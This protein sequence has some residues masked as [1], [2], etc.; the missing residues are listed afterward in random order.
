MPQ[1][2]QQVEH[3][4][5]AV[6]ARLQQGQ[7]GQGAHLQV[8]LREVTGVQGVVAA[9]VR[10]RR[11]F[12]DDER[13]VLQHKKLHAQHAHVMQAVRDG[14]GGGNGL[15]GQFGRQVAVKHFGHRQNTVAVQVE[16]HRQVDASA[17]PATRHDH[18]AFGTQRQHFFQHAGH[19]LE[20]RPGGGQFGAGGDAGLALAVV[21]Q[22]RGFENARQQVVRHASELLGGLDH[23]VGRAGHAAAHKM[24]L[25]LGPVLGNAHRFGVGRHGPVRA[26][27]DE[28]GRRHVFK[29]GGD[30]GT[31][32]H[33]LRQ[34]LFVEVIGL[35]VV[36]AHQ[37]GGADHVG[38]EHHGEIT[39]GLRCL[40]KHAAQLA[41]PHHAQ[42]GGLTLR[43]AARQNSLGTHSAGGSVMARAAWVCAAR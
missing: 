13:A 1:V 27:G 6:L 2:T 11:H 21:A 4:G 43:A 5:R 32:L 15:L 37:T 39:H 28:G 30:G 8:K 40:H 3:D 33:Q 23:G 26:Q 38:V 22:P 9:V 35:D 14:A 12:V 16:L 36:V 20:R 17:V 10:T 41:T 42:C 25:F 24:R 18:R 34:A 19:A 31:A 29:L 7:A